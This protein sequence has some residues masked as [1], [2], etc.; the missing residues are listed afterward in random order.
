LFG[1]RGS[2][3]LSEGLAEAA[4]GRLSFRQA[5]LKVITSQVWSS[6]STEI[7]LGRLGN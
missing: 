3:P 2:L 4:V 6:S 1:M 5:C 7:L